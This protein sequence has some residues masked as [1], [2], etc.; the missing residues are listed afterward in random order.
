[1]LDLDMSDHF[2]NLNLNE[3]FINIIYL[4]PA[5]NKDQSPGHQSATKTDLHINRN[6]NCRNKRKNS[7]YL[8]VRLDGIFE[9]SNPNS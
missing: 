8:S 9:N 1:M 3:Y 4:T 6:K 5:S 2:L 7:K